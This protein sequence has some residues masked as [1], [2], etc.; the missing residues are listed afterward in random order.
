[1]I[2]P[3]VPSPGSNVPVRRVST[4]PMEIAP[5]AALIAL[6]IMGGSVWGARA[7]YDSVLHLEA[8]LDHLERGESLVPGRAPAP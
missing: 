2:D 3:P 5:P 4:E 8:L 1:M 7:A 6:P